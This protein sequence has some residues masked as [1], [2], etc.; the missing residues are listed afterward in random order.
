VFSFSSF[1]SGCAATH[2]FFFAAAAAATNAASA[3]PA[4]HTPEVIAMYFART[5]FSPT[6]GKRL[7]G[8]AVMKTQ[9]R[10]A[11]FISHHDDLEAAMVVVRRLNER[12]AS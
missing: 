11:I 5:L 4:T 9:D 7:P 1:F 3:D 10:N 12:T 6:T 2:V 8:V